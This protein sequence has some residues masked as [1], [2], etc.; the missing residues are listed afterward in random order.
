M[1][2]NEMSL[3]ERVNISKVSLQVPLLV[4]FAPLS[5]IGLIVFGVY[6]ANHW[7]DF[8]AL[9]STVVSWSVTL[10][11][12][13]AIIFVC[14]CGSRAL[15]AFIEAMLV[16]AHGV[17]DVHGKFVENSAAS[18]RRVL[19][20]THDTY[21]VYLQDGKVIAQPMIPARVTSPAGQ[22][23]A[24]TT[25][26]ELPPAAELP[27]NVSYEDV[28]AQVP[29]GHVLV[30]VGRKGVETKDR[31][32]A[33]ACVW[34][35]GLSGTGKTS[36]T[37]LR[38][39]E[40]RT[41][42]HS[43]LVVDPHWFK[44]DSLSNAIATYQD[45]FLMPIARTSEESLAVLQAFLGEF[46]GRKAGR[47]PQPWRKITLLIDEVNA[48]MDPTAPKGTPERAAQDEI[49]ELLPTIARVCGQEARNFN[50]GGIFVSQQATGLAWLRK[51]A[52]MIIVHQL[53]MDSEKTIALQGDRL[54]MEEMKS[55]PIGRT[56]VYGVGFNELPHAVQ[57][58][59][60]HTPGA[61]D[62]PQGEQPTW[63]YNGAYTVD[64]APSGDDTG[65]G[66]DELPIDEDLREAIEAWESGATGPRAMQ[67]ALGC[68]YYR[69]QQLCSEL[70]EKGLV[71]TD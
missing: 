26:E 30:G 50:M 38:V 2:D 6:M 32:I 22:I 40:R 16:L 36:T 27:T 43:F 33:G 4:I 13:V 34:I 48:L 12:A 71:E 70:V 67:R 54:A 31:K 61:A 20:H 69:A 8:V 18:K 63:T 56:Y 1:H 68:T 25:V 5:L 65:E 7:R 58:P 44:P 23:T 29:P 3:K 57:Q 51:V 47:I 14:Y 42:G 17:A 24:P 59:Y 37:V 28:R 55:W 11:G 52:L 41:D 21:V 19:L 45:D 10:L 60:F 53:L 15:K 49:A 9:T 39:E 64:A 46:D 35:V 66:E 62:R